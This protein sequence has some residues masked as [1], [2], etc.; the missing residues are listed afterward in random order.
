M[1]K[2]LLIFFLLYSGCQLNTEPEDE[3]YQ[4]KYEVSGTAKK[5]NITMENEGG[6]TSQYSDVSVPWEYNF[7]GRK[8]SGTF[9]YV[10]AQSQNESG[11][12]IATIY[13][14]NG[15][16][17]TSTSSGAYVIATASGSF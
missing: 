8:K 14:N 1:K 16:F 5:V 6:G 11:T 15:T 7:P 12:V 9:V 13:K 2:L 17:K 10:S 4:V 3:T